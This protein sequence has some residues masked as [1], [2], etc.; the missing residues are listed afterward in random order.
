M[1]ENSIFYLVKNW[2][3]NN[4]FSQELTVYQVFIDIVIPFILYNLGKREISKL[5]P[6]YK[7][8]HILLNQINAYHSNIYG[9][10]L[11][12][13]N[14]V[15]H[16]RFMNKNSLRPN[17]IY[18]NNYIDII[19]NSDGTYHAVSDI[20]IDAKRNLSLDKLRDEFYS[21]FH[22]KC[23]EDFILLV[24]K[25]IIDGMKKG[26]VK[27]SVWF[28][29]TGERSNNLSNHPYDYCLFEGVK[30]CYILSE[31]ADAKAVI[32]VL[33]LLRYEKFRSVEENL[34]Q[35]IVI[36]QMIVNEIPDWIPQFIRNKLFVYYPLGCN[37]KDIYKAIQYWEKNGNK[38]YYECNGKF[39]RKS[40]YQIKGKPER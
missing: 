9:K 15:I 6:E 31:A 1:N 13:K 3:N 7:D 33:P 34:G 23:K 32:K 18:S 26:I 14:G 21:L 38:K 27:S 36:A 25:F 40:S 16:I 22:K 39:I 30:Y 17:K 5:L 11:V 19:R 20:S 4:L 37:L 12:R 24:D 35:S 29:G 28:D 8:I 10:L 2:L